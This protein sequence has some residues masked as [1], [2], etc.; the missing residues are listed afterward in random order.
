M[1]EGKQ[2]VTGH[3]KA[4]LTIRQFSMA[5]FADLPRHKFIRPPA[6][7]RH[8]RD[9]PHSVSDDKVRLRRRSFRQEFWNFGRFMLTVA[10]HKEKQSKTIVCLAQPLLNRCSLFQILALT[11]Y[12]ISSR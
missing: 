9:I 8:R 4:A 1:Q 7:N 2:F 12:I 11:N 5:Q 10:I 6:N 3:S